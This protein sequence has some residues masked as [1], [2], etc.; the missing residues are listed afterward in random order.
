MQKYGIHFLTV[1][2]H[3]R[4]RAVVGMTRRPK[5]R[6]WMGVVFIAQNL[7]KKADRLSHPPMFRIN[8]KEF[9]AFCRKSKEPQKVKKNSSGP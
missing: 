9:Q 8:L 5:L 2:C 7:P 3:D 1:K 6:K 4:N